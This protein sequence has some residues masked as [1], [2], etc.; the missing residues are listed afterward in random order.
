MMLNTKR[1]VEMSCADTVSGKDAKPNAKCFHWL[2][3][4]ISPLAFRQVVV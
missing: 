3:S 1:D 4:Q 2:P